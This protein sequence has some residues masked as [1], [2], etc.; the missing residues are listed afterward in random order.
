MGGTRLFDV[1]L[2][3]RRE[4]LVQQTEL[5]LLIED[6]T[7][8]QGIQR[9]LLDAITEAPQRDGV[10]VLCSIRVAMAVTSGYF[11]TLAETFSTRAQFAGHVY[12]LDVPRSSSGAGV[13]DEEIVDFVGGYLNASRLGQAQLEE[14]LRAAGEVRESNRRW[15]PN[16]CDE[17]QH[18]DRCHEAF[19]TTSDGLGLYPFNAAALN[20]A[21]ESRSPLNFDPR[22]ILGTVIRY[23]LDQHRVD[24]GRGEFPSS[25]FLQ[26]FAT[27]S[28]PPLAAD[29]VED[30]RSADPI[31]ADRR[32]TLLTFW[33]GLPNRVVNLEPGIHEAFSLPLLGDAELH[34]PARSTGR[35]VEREKTSL[36]AEAT[37]L[38]PRIQTRLDDINQWASGT[39][40]LDQALA[41][42]LRRFL[43]AAIVDSIDWN[44]ELLH[45]TDDSIGRNGQHFRHSSI[46]I[47]NA[48]GGGTIPATAVTIHVPVSA[49]SATLLQ[50]VVLYEHHGNWRFDRG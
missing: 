31:D 24:L 38:P 48:L 44:A 11:A 19:G 47:D 37:A 18:Q 42:D 26:H 8:L 9:E 32:V 35:N 41:G 6:F 40:Q 1:M 45:P 22:R 25:S 20:R 4:L 30:I 43:H 7:I 13:G 23:T 2:S 29:V 16:A 3:V 12:S 17:C 28:L 36:T 27:S 15:V 39:T 14:A 21:V 46:R 49:S 34:R 5:V 33:G 50:A 10:Q